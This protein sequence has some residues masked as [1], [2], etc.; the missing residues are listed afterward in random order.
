M[1]TLLVLSVGWKVVDIADMVSNTE[2]LLPQHLKISYICIFDWHRHYSAQLIP[3]LEAK[4]NHS[5]L[6]MEGIHLSSSTDII[7]SYK[8]HWQAHKTL[9]E[10]DFSL[11]AFHKS[12]NIDWINVIYYP[13]ILWMYYFDEVPDV[14]IVLNDR[15][16][17]WQIRV[18]LT[19][20]TLQL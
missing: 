2:K 17:W 7:H 16:A 6:L 11:D 14:V 20:T 15:V 5:M 1:P 4:L 12:F 10:H 9:P 18:Q 19:E 8:E 13:R 3:M